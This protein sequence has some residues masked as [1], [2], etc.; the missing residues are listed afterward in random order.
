MMTLVMMTVGSQQLSAA[1]TSPLTASAAPLSASDDGSCEHQMEYVAAVAATCTADGILAHY[2]CTVCGK[3]FKDESG[4][5]ELAS[6][7]A[8]V[9][10]DYESDDYDDI[11]ND[12]F[13][14]CNSTYSVAQALCDE[15]DINSYGGIINSLSFYVQQVGSMTGNVKIY[16]TECDYDELD[17]KAPITADK[18]TLVYDGT[19]TLGTQSGWEAIT[20]QHPFIYTGSSIVVTVVCSNMQGTAPLYRNFQFDDDDYMSSIYRSGTTSDICDLSDTSGYSDHIGCTHFK[21][22][23]GSHVCKYVEKTGTCTTGSYVKPHYE[24]KNCGSIF[25]DS[26]ALT[27]TTLDDLT[28]T[29]S[30][31]HVIGDDYVCTVCGQLAVNADGVFEIGSLEQ[32]N[33]FAKYVNAGNSNVN[34]CLTADITGVTTPV[35]TYYTTYY[36]GVFDGQGHTIDINLTANSGEYSLFSYLSSATVKNLHVTGTINAGMFRYIGGIVGRSEASDLQQLWSSVTITSARD[37]EQQVYIGGI[38]ATNNLGSVKDCLFDGVINAELAYYSSGIA[39]RMT[40]YGR[41]YNCLNMGTMNVDTTRA[42]YYISSSSN[43]YNC[44]YLDT[45]TATGMVVNGEVTAVTTEQLAS[46]EMVEKLNGS[47]GSGQWRKDVLLGHPVQLCMP[48]NGGQHVYTTSQYIC[49]NCGEIAEHEHQFPETSDMAANC[50]YPSR[51]YCQLCN[52]LLADGKA[53]I[54]ANTHNYENK[55][56]TLCGKLETNANGELEISTLDEWNVFVSQAQSNQT[57]KACLTADITGVTTP[58]GTENTPYEGTFDG[59][60]HTL[61]IALTAT[62][63]YYAPFWFV[64]DATI[65]NVH[66]TGTVDGKDRFYIGGVVGSASGN[67]TLQQLWS[68]VDITTTRDDCTYGGV[69]GMDRDGQT[70]TVTDCLFD[71]SITGSNAYNCAGIVG[72]VGNNSTATI[73]NCLV[74]GTFDTKTN[75]CQAIARC[76][77]TDNCTITNCYYNEATP[78]SASNGGTAITAE[79]LLTAATTLNGESGIGNWHKVAIMDYPIPTAGQCATHT[80]T[81]YPNLCDVC[82][83]ITEHEHQFP[84]TSETPATCISPSMSHCT[85]C[86]QYLVDGKAEASETLHNFVGGVCTYC[87]NYKTNESGEFEITS[88]ESWVAFTN[89]VANGEDI[90]ACLTADI[91]GVTT[92]VGSSSKPFKGTFDGKGHSLDIAFTATGEYYAPFWFVDGATIKDLHVT[93]TLNADNKQYI[94]GIVGSASGTTTLQQLWS[95]VS[96]STTKYDCTYGGVLGMKR[97]GQSITITDCLFDGTISGDNAYNCAGIAGW[98]E[99]GGTATIENC[100]V[101]ATFSTKT[102]GCQ[103]IARRKTA[104]NLTISNCYYTEG[105]TYSAGNG[106]TALSADDIASDGASILNKWNIGNWHKM[107]TMDHPVPTTSQCTTHTCTT[108]ANFCD[109]CG[110]ITEHTHAFPETSDISATCISPSMSQ[111]SLCGHLIVDGK[112]EASETLHIYSEGKCIYCKKLK[113]NDDGMFEIGTLDDWNNFIGFVADGEDISACLT[114]DVTGVTTPAGSSDS[115]FKGTF[116]G[117]GHTLGIELTATGGYYAPFWFVDGATIKNLRVIGNINAS[118]KQYIGGIV[119]SA[120]GTTTLQRLWSSVSIS[121]TKDDCTYG[122]V[123]GMKRDGQSITITDCLFDGTISGTDA[124]N[125]AGIAGWIE[126]GGTATIENCLVTATF[127]TETDG[128]QVIARRKTADNLTISNCYYNEAITYS[129]DNGGTT[130]TDKQLDGEALSLLNGNALTGNWC[131][132]ADMLYPVPTAVQCTE[133]TYTTYANCCDVCGAITEHDHAFPAESDIPVT[134]ISSDSWSY[135]TLCHLLLDDGN[136]S[137]TPK[138]NTV[139]VDGVS[140]TE[141]GTPKHYHCQ[142]CEKDFLD[143]DGTKSITYST[144]MVEAALDGDVEDD[145]KSVPYDRLYEDS[146]YEAGMTAMLYKAAEIGRGGKIASIAYNVAKAAEE[147]AKIRIY[148]QDTDSTTVTNA[149]TTDGMTLVY[150]GTPQRG[151]TTG[152]ETLT[153]DKP[154]WH[155][156]T[157]NLLIVTQY[158]EG[159]TKAEDLCYYSV[160]IP[161]DENLAVARPIDTQEWPDDYWQLSNR[162]C[163][164]LGFVKHDIQYV[165]R[166]GDC[167]TD[168]YVKSHY[169]CNVCGQTYE[170]AE[171]ATEVNVDDL[172]TTTSGSHQFDSYGYCAVCDALELNSDSVYEISSVSRWYSFAK[173]VNAGNNTV[174]AALTVNIKGYSGVTMT[175][176]LAVGT[177]N[178]PYRGTFNGNGHIIGF[179]ASGDNQYCAPFGYIDGATVKNLHRAVEIA[180]TGNFEEAIVSN[181]TGNSKIQRIWNYLIDTQNT[182]KVHSGGIVSHIINGTNGGNVEISDCLMQGVYS[183]NINPTVRS[184]YCIADTIDAQSHAQIKRCLVYSTDKC[185]E[186]IIANYDGDE[187]TCVISDCHFLSTMSDSA[188]SGCASATTAEAKDGTLLGKLNDADPEGNNYWMQNS[189]YNIPVPVIYTF[190]IKDE[191]GITS[192]LADYLPATCDV[193]LKGRTLYKDGYYNTLSLP[194]SLNSEQLA[195]SPLAG[196]KLM[197]INGLSYNEQTSILTI[198]M[199]EADAITEGHPYL[200]KWEADD[201]NITD[202]VFHQVQ[203]KNA[204][205]T[206]VID[207]NVSCYANINPHAV[208]ANDQKTLFLGAENKLYYPDN[209]G[210]INSCRCYFT[211]SDAAAGAKISTVVFNENN[212]ATGIS[213]ANN[214]DDTDAHYNISGQH[215]TDSYRGIVISGGKKVVRK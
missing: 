25:A 136:T 88:A 116:D 55:L 121:T 62:S 184:K 133:H 124:Y 169:Q 114:A 107:A 199:T 26:K 128:C 143:A 67:T 212:T 79:A 98:I 164:Q 47:D 72:W 108:Y 118:D 176:P 153:F 152:W 187:N 103:V 32:W 188:Y 58:V 163:L 201:E 113:T 167:T 71:G 127:S 206:S 84:E 106:G 197:E 45:I 5:N 78:Y 7:V 130:L 101:T 189:T 76:I 112:T 162:A 165:A 156:E 185:T 83:T 95:S 198:D 111:C 122:G 90:N 24:C 38:V 9:Y 157:S 131:K 30:G 132:T 75:G 73:V 159:G 126:Q 2:H 14:Y 196:A 177:V 120:S 50:T 203:L 96:I 134:C 17:P 23:I 186:N 36:S 6:I 149:F 138:H 89:L 210:N 174:D 125:C 31:Q 29:T 40:S 70:V 99:Q 34:A 214:A 13:P 135:C 183:A 64:S 33:A 60:G 15:E 49:D 35:G 137:A 209:D 142:W 97:D 69:L 65:K 41:A 180:N 48:C 22:S 192:T 27:A 191:E 147:N 94:G 57:L 158:V 81:T 53:E 74:N 215:I 154:F 43:E 92:P 8:S 115:P 202:P 12:A 109:V 105:I 61:G 182:S 119:G 3:N 161:E 171:G 181:A 28:V 204:T 146:T 102:A 19:L 16:L 82:G 205:S 85:L 86:N 110:V 211:L 160:E 80:F 44:Y 151:L 20:L 104:D 39:G 172:T 21:F 140:C 148:L 59:N 145:F 190:E 51:S 144:E 56:C 54:D 155:T 173:A 213:S 166:E 179:F 129:A 10:T 11:V 194:F 46:A 42:N 193:T 1:K 200:I 37:D 175:T 208:T 168:K 178:Q 66:V 195:D 4:T 117:K 100:L 63:Y 141:E 150:E 170:D 52:Q 93:G 123:I 87:G 139:L 207:S 18:M 77:T 68:S 91:T